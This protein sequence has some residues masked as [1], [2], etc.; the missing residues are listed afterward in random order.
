MVPEA[1]QNKHMY[2]RGYRNLRRPLSRKNS[3]SL[4]PTRMIYV[5]DNMRSIYFL[6]PNLNMFWSLDVT[7]V[8][9]S[10]LICI[11]RDAIRHFSLLMGESYCSGKGKIKC[12]RDWVCKCE[13]SLWTVTVECFPPMVGKDR[14]LV[15]VTPTPLPMTHPECCLPSS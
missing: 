5:E 9:S 3:L 7:L 8:C 11:Y 14:A 10:T 2:Y 15:L 4:L 1:N 6:F 13:K 12:S